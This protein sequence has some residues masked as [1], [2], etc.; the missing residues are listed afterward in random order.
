MNANIL[1]L[2]ISAL[3]GI[4][5]ALEGIWMISLFLLLVV[6]L[7]YFKVTSKKWI[8]MYIIFLLIF[9]VLSKFTISQNKTQL[10]PNENQYQIYFSDE[11]KIN[12]D[13]MRAIVHESSSK[14]KL[15]FSYKIPT[16]EEKRQITHIPLIGF[17][18]KVI[19]NLETPEQAR[20]ENSFNYRNYLYQNYIHWQLKV[21]EWDLSNCEQKRLSFLE[22]LKKWRILGISRI[23]RIFSE[24]AGPIAAALIFG[25]RDLL[26]EDMIK[27]YQKLGV[28]HLISISG[29]HVALLIGMLFYLGIRI[30]LV[31]EK[32]TF[33]LLLILP[34]YAIITGATP[35]VNRAVMMAAFILLTGLFKLPIRLRSID[36][37]CL[38]F[39]LITFINP[40]IIYN[41]GFQ[42]SYIVTISLLISTNIIGRYTSYLSQMV[43]IS[44]IS[45]TAALPFLLYHFF[46]IPLISLLANILYIP[47]YS[48]VFLPGLMIAYILSFISFD[49]SHLLSGILSWLIKI[50]NELAF[51]STNFTQTR[52]VPGRPATFFVLLY[53]IA[54]LISFYYW[55]KRRYVLLTLILPWFV[56]VSQLLSPYFSSEGEVSIID[57]GQGDSILIQLPHNKGNYLIDTGGTITFPSESWKKKKQKFEVGEDILIPYLKGK[58]VTKLDLLILTHGDMDHIGGSLALLKEVAV[59]QILMPNVAASKSNIEKEVIKLAKRQ[60]T[61]I[62]YINEGISWRADDSLFTVLA[63]APHFTG[64]KNDGSIVLLAQLGG[65]NWLFT[66]DLGKEGERLLLQKY[67]HMKIHVLKVGHHGSKTSTSTEFIQHYSPEYA[68]ITVGKKNRFGHPH[69]SVLKILDTH[70]SLILRTDI[71]GEISYKF[72]ANTRT[73]STEIP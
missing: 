43:V 65:L 57:V 26:E 51:W 23:E 56:M 25:S 52:I 34:F 68:I 60:N 13:Q 35:P 46:E 40:L 61:R 31:R 69:S 54:I 49:I 9:F 72:N 37:L 58:G 53:S 19:G 47:L 38:S 45:Q 59:K 1:F 17:S 8:L 2:T 63:P 48:F 22:H 27:A 11:V 16:N 5:S 41:I 67:P 18:C 21:S 50:S 14:E 36:G 12:G 30:G 39:L 7:F 28:I 62:N 33:C 4:L 42:L 32:V 20:N 70:H 3:L 29:L 10:D 73:F 6:Y 15:V 44:Y 66:G 55:E 64:D 24:D 71:Y